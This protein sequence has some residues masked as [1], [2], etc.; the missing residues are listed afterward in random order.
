MAAAAGAHASLVTA[1]LRAGADPNR[2]TRTGNTALRTAIT[3]G[4]GDCIA[5]LLEG[6]A[7][8]NMETARGTP[9]VVACVRGDP[10]VVQQLIAAGADVEKETRAAQT[11]LLAAT[12]E[13]KF[14]AVK[15]LLEAGA[16]PEKESRVRTAR[17]I[18]RTCTRFVSTLHCAR[19]A[20]H[21]KR[22]MMSVHKV[23]PMYNEMRSPRWW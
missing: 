11:P 1:I 19:G 4:D 18:R 10:A 5:A 14:E 6:G 7:S 9:L 22:D 20:H 16:D 21:I 8:V 13:G 3:L 15:A 17:V 2:A 12:R 23:Y